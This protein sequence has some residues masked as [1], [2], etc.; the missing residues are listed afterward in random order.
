M[1]HNKNK[2]GFTIVELVIVIGVIG[3]LA[4]ILIPTF[5]NV[6]P[7]AEEAAAKSEVAN[8]F[9]SYVAD[10]ADGEIDKDNVKAVI[11]QEYS[12]E[13]TYTIAL[14]KQ[15]DAILVRKE[16]KYTYDSEKGWVEDASAT[17]SSTLLVT[18]KQTSVDDVNLTPK[19]NGIDIYQKAA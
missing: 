19:Y 2:K 6:T 8:A 14:I 1:K 3:I 5:V 12:A 4:G 18:I 9:S 17:Q 15:Q 13:K 7:R 10:A 16:V 11:N